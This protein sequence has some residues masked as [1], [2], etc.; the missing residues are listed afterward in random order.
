MTEL[1]CSCRPGPSSPASPASPGPAGRTA[2]LRWTAK[3]S[4]Y[5]ISLSVLEWLGRLLNGASKRPICMIPA[6][7]ALLFRLGEGDS[8]AGQPPS[9]LTA[10]TD[11]RSKPTWSTTPDR[12]RFRHTLSS[13]GRT[14]HPRSISSHPCCRSV[15][16]AATA[17]SGEEGRQ[18]WPKMTLSQREGGAGC[19]ARQIAAT[20]RNVMA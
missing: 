4:A 3:I 14:D 1:A 12:T 11:Q 2:G 10:T 17:K 13:C 19:R 8:P 5:F 9:H 7:P 20:S 6:I 15:V 18:S 16:A